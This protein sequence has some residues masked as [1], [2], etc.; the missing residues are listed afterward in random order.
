MRTSLQSASS[1]SAMISGSEV[2]DPCPISVAAD[3]MVIVP[4][5][6][7]LTHGLS[8]LPTRSVAG[9]AASARPDSTIANESPAA[10]IMTCRRVRSSPREARILMCLFMARLPRGALDRPHDAL[11]GAAAAD[12]A[13]YVFDDLCT[14]RLRL[15]LEQIGRAHNLARLAIPALRHPLGQP[16]LLHRMA[17]VW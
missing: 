13:A 3:M 1:S 10:P 2:I 8:S 16:G 12:V 17:G 11:I 5:G 15:M 4:S 6:A 9:T 14:R 7:M